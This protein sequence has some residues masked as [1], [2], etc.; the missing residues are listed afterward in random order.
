MMLLLLVMMRSVIGADNP[1]MESLLLARLGVQTLHVRLLLLLLMLLLPH[2]V[3]RDALIEIHAYT[4][5]R[6]RGFS[7]LSARPARR[8]PL[9]LAIPKCALSLL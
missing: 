5:F 7:Q 9:F 1:R 8:R 2:V 4:R 3:R 6:Y